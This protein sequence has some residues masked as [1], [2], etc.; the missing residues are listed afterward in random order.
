MYE[1]FVLKPFLYTLPLIKNSN[2]TFF[3]S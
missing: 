2:N 3:T 1:R